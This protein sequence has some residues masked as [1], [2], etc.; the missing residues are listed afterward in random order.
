[1]EFC[2]NRSFPMRWLCFLL[3]VAFWKSCRFRSYN[4][5]LHWSRCIVSRLLCAI[6]M[7]MRVKSDKSKDFVR[8][9]WKYIVTSLWT[10]S[11]WFNRK[12]Y[13]DV[14]FNAIQIKFKGHLPLIET[15]LVNRFWKKKF[16]DSFEILLNNSCMFIRIL[17]LID[18]GASHIYKVNT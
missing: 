4:C 9:S 6:F 3:F 14:N 15:K 8:S 12:K 2:M 17:W 11:T 1:M 5:T 13:R 18:S 10:F 16:L 7:V